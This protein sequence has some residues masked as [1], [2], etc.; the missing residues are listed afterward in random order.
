[1]E[2]KLLP[3]TGFP[4]EFLPIVSLD[5]AIY[6]PEKSINVDASWQV[7]GGQVENLFMCGV[8]YFLS[9]SIP[10]SVFWSNRL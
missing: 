7:S 2:I 3:K 4:E 8:Y 9:L 5:Q 6:F 10:F 1:M